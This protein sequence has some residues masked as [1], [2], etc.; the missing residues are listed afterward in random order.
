[1]IQSTSI[2]E[3]L[4]ALYMVREAWRATVYGVAK[5]QTRLSTH[6]N[7]HTH[8]HTQYTEE[9]GNEITVENGYFSHFP[10]TSFLEG[11]LCKTQ[12]LCLT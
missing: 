3:C 4:S 2:F 5:S 9:C 6:A 8:T 11:D 12:T 10:L 7:T 1:M